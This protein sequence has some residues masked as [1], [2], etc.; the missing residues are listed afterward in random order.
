MNMSV[1]I[2]TSPSAAT[3]RIPAW[4][5]IGL[6][7]KYAKDTWDEDVDVLSSAETAAVNA[8][9][10]AVNETSSNKR[11]REPSEKFVSVKKR[12]TSAARSQEDITRTSKATLP[13][14]TTQTAVPTLNI[15]GAD[16]GKPIALQPAGAKHT[17]FATEE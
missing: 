8:P 5:R 6:K 2:E 13:P 16:F 3:K 14:A 9:P 15:T 12:K 4:K 17:K 7:L 1:G 10:T 11:S